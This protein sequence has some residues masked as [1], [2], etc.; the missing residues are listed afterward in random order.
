[1]KT[2]KTRI[3]YSQINVV[4]EVGIKGDNLQTREWRVRIET[5]PVNITK[6]NKYSVN[7]SS[8]IHNVA[9]KSGKTTTV[10]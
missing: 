9:F 6:R 4:A 3:N 2:I 8:V 5:C 1:M 7:N 10:N